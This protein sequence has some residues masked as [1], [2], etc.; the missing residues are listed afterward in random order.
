VLDDDELLKIPSRR[1]I[2][3]SKIIFKPI[4]Q[5]TRSIREYFEFPDKLTRDEYQK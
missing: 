5:P 3:W 2:D 1:K 4:T